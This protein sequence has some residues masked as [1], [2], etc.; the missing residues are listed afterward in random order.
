[1]SNPR[2]DPFSTI[3]KYHQL[4][5]ILRNKIEDGEWEANQAIPSERELEKTYDVS[6]TTIRQA[7]TQLQVLGF[8]YR[9][10]G[11]GT[12][13]APQKLQNSLHELTSFS[14]D[15]KDRGLKPGQKILELGFIEPPVFVRQQL[16]LP[17]SV[18]QVFILKRLRMADDLPIGLHFAYLPFKFDQLITAEEIEEHG[19]LYELLHLKY[20]LIPSGY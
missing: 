18:N 20:N 10:L 16:E 4:L 2:I 9:K 7:L 15:M 5:T 12:F 17:D 13:V 8:V 1:M 19:S 6:R 11:K 3:P 14:N